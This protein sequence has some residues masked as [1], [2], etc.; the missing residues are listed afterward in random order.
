MSVWEWGLLAAI[1]AAVVIL[2]ER[3]IRWIVRRERR[4]SGSGN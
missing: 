1:L 2:V 3:F 4:R